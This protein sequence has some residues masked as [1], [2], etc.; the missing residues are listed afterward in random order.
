MK[1]V[2]DNP[3]PAGTDTVMPETDNLIPDYVYHDPD[4]EADEAPGATE[5]SDEGQ[6]DDGAEVEAETDEADDEA[7][8]D[9]T[10]A[11]GEESE[12]D[13]AEQFDI[14]GVGAVTRDELVKGY[15]RQADYTRKTQEAAEVRK[16]VTQELRELQSVQEAF[17]NHVSAMV[18]P[19]PDPALAM[20][21][22][23]AYTRAKAQYDAALTRVEGLIK[24]ARKPREMGESLSQQEQAELVQRESAALAQRFPQITRDKDRTAFFN[25]IGDVAQEAGFSSEEL[26]QLADHRFFVVAHW[27]AEGLKAAK[28]RAKAKTTAKAAPQAPAAPRQPAGTRKGNQNREAMKKLARSGSIR[29]ALAVDFD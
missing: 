13:K 19:Q 17:I 23:A 11:E 14:P 15:L 28:A 29:D 4:D 26:S 1:D 16:R 2:T 8:T 5:E 27:A 20:S 10:E 9:G 3:A 18:P 22:P 21:D 25:A 7:D 24:Q 12:A 6:A